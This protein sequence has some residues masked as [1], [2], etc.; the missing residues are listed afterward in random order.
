MT[1]K[2]QEIDLN[3]ENLNIG[4]F[5]NNGTHALHNTASIKIINKQD[6]DIL[7]ILNSD[8]SRWFEYIF[9]KKLAQNKI[10]L[11]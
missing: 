8:S 6:T 5:T 7:K 9:N 4:V 2:K 10:P 1:G 3:V 11:R